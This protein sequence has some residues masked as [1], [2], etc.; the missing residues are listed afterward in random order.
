TIGDYAFANCQMLLNIT[1]SDSLEEIGAYA[2]NNCS[3]LDRITIPA[4]VSHIGEYAFYGS[5]L[6]QAVFENS[7]NWTTS[8]AA[9]SFSYTYDTQS[10]TYP[11]YTRTYTYQLSNKESAAKALS[12]SVTITYQTRANGTT[13]SKTFKWYEYEWTRSDS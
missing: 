8:G 3:R 10:T 9:F 12:E 5:A 2:F 1:L 6:T 7:N 4:S 11:P 13:A